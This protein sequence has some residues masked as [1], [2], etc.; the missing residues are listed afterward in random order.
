MFT[1]MFDDTIILNILQYTSS[2]KDYK[3]ACLVSKQF[4]QIITKLFPG[5]N[6]FV[7]HLLTLLKLY[8]DENWD[9]TELSLNVNISMDYISQHLTKD[10]NYKVLSA[11]PSIKITDIINYPILQKYPSCLSN[12]PNITLDFVVS[13]PKI[14]WDYCK[15][16][17]N[18]NI[19]IEYLMNIYRKCPDKFY[20]LGSISF[21]PNITM[22]I[23]ENNTDIPWDYFCLSQYVNINV[24]ANNINKPWNFSKLSSRRDINFTTVINN[25]DKPWD[26]KLLSSNSA[27]TIDMV[28][29]YPEL[30]WDHFYLTINRSMTESIMNDNL[31]IVWAK[32][33]FNVHDCDE[34]CLDNPS[35][36]CNLYNI[37]KWHHVVNY[38]HLNW[39]FRLL[40]N[41]R[42]GK[43]RKI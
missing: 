15:L 41:N 31:D 5:G 1:F 36:S 6:K 19:P 11:N 27:I 39:D 14:S 28:K 18:A 43:S 33:A 34:A 30:P 22:D 17:K 2:G 8:P 12:N 21:N 38:P 9:Y 4:Y 32:N 25:L 35:K 7:N 20:D 3:N 24:I 37:V 13:H 10:W 29:K 23:I 40:S 26:W 16:A 42:F